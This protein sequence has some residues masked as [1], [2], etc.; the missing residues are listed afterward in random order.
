M[1]YLRVNKSL[2]HY[3]KINL[4]LNYFI[5]FIPQKHLSL[6]NRGSL[7]KFHVQMNFIQNFGRSTLEFV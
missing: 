5:K 3:L 1:N 4:Q 6:T 7:T 2:C